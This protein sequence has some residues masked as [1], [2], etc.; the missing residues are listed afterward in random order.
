M[1]PSPD[2]TSREGSGDQ[3]LLKVRGV[4]K[5]FPG[6]MALQGID[7]DLRK[8]E[9][10][11][12]LGENGAGKSTLMK[13]ISGAY[14]KDEGEIR[15]GGQS[16]EIL[17]PRHAQD[18][19]IATIYQHFNQVPHL[20]VAE[21]LFLGREGARF[22]FIDY[23][24]LFRRARAALDR[25]RLQVDL[26]TRIRDLSIAQRQ[27]IEIAKALSLRS[28]I[29]IMDEPTSALTDR[30]SD[31]LFA[32]I[33]ALRDDGIGT[34]Y[35]SHRL[36]EVKR[37]A[38]RVTVLRDGKTVGTL[39][40]DK[41]DVPTIIRMMVGREVQA[42]CIGRCAADGDELLRVESLT[43]RGVLHDVSFSAKRGEIVSLFGLMGAG[44]TEVARAIFGVDPIDGGKVYVAG[45]PVRISSPAEAVRHG[46]GFLTEDRLTSGL[47][48]SLSVT[49]NI[50]LPSLARFRIGKWLL[51]LKAE[52]EAASGYVSAL[53]IHTPSP[54][55][56]VQHLSGGN[57][58]KVV[59][60]KWLMAGSAMLIMDEPTQGIDVR[61][62]AEVHRLMIDFAR[63]KRGSVLLISSDLP[64]VLRMSDRILVM[65]EGRLV[66]EV[67]AE[68]AS[69]E[70]IME[71]ATGSR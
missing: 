33:E 68:H 66:A 8:G 48:M 63:T 44:R 30:E 55:H 7:F 3:E 60:A 5:R 23:G 9:V 13:I 4:S 29:I 19:G 67:P 46:L 35:I 32:I 36:E 59:L 62:K 14:R 40:A 6:V 50:T 61:G 43:R 2:V 65:H 25:V 17:T 16:V 52:R 18:L 1:A 11:A 27:M 53:D 42:T 26:R 70:L 31:T 47:A 20:S 49:H 12:L 15:I 37:I 34:I 39:R 24:D 38:D 28:R 58:Q 41:A 69:Q 10:H 51:N 71:Y 64:E 22:G 57:Q 56:A 54:D 45:R 21:N